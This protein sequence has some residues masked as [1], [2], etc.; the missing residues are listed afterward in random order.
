MTN[1]RV[2]LRFKSFSSIPNLIHGFS[3]REFGSMRPCQDG[4]EIS[5]ESFSKSL[6]INPQKIVSMHQVHSNNI[7]WVNY[8]D[9]GR[10]VDQTDGIFTSEKDLFLSILSGDCMPI[11]IYDTQKKYVGVVHAGWRGIYNEILI[12]AIEELKAKGS[13]TDDLIIGI[14]P[15]IRSCCYNVSKER[16]DMFTDKFPKAQSFLENRKG[17]IFLDLVSIAKYQLQ[18]AGIPAE[19][20]EDCGICTSD[21]VDKFFSFRKEED[22]FGEFI[23]IIDRNA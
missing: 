15:C 3:T 14:G 12:K 2:V 1:R 22:I 7:A 17:K 13:E 21:N 10:R 9:K 18:E 4:S 19:N 20:I 6:K 16:T 8:K 23:G 11:F 5:L